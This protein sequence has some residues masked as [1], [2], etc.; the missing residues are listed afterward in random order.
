M[1]LVPLR[2]NSLILRFFLLYPT[3]FGIITY[4]LIRWLTDGRLPFAT[5]GMG[6]IGLA[7]AYC[8]LLN[9]VRPDPDT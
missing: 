9:L 6:C 1:R 5:Y 8:M 2:L 7:V 3:I 4:P